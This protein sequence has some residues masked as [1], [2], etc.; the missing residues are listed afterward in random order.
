MTQKRESDVL[1]IAL[2]VTLTFFAVYLSIIMIL[3]SIDGHNLKESN[4]RIETRT[5][6]QLRKCLVE[7]SQ[8]HYDHTYAEES[9]LVIINRNTGKLCRLRQPDYSLITTEYDYCLASYID[10]FELCND[11]D[12][13]DG[14]GATFKHSII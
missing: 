9:D 10:S 6:G 5:E 12:K 13:R 14:V 8:L 3:Q 1:H 4:K 2:N 7:I 11:A